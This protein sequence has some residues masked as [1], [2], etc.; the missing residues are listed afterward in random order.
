MRGTG[1]VVRPRQPRDRIVVVKWNVQCFDVSWQA[2]FLSHDAGMPV[3]ESPDAT[4]GCV[5]EHLTHGT[6]I[7]LGGRSAPD[8]IVPFAGQGN[9]NVPEGTVATATSGEDR[10]QPGKLGHTDCEE[11][12]RLLPAGTTTALIEMHVSRTACA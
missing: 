6:I 5:S 11:A 1:T 3:K 4:E 7:G 2:A 8:A 12:G 10:D 9:V